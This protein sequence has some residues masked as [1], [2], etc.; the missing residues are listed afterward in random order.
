MH[1]I[2]QSGGLVLALMFLAGACLAQDK[3]DQEPHRFYRLDFLVKELDGGKVLNSRVYS[4]QVATEGGDN[5]IRTVSKIPFATS[6]G[7]WTQ[8]D[9]GTNIDCSNIREVQGEL[10]LKISAEVSSVLEDPSN[11]GRPIIRQNQWRSFVLLKLKK[12]TVVFSSDDVSSKRQMQLEVTAT[13]VTPG[14]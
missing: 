10:S 2:K 5:S 12:P 13:P 7:S 8:I 6:P 4:M 9:V 11:S 1:R 3:P 14:S